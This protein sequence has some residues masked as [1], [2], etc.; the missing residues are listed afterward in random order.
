MF[1]KS[2]VNIMANFITIMSLTSGFLAAYL[3][4]NNKYIAGAIFFTLSGVLDV[5]DGYVARRTGKVT[6]FGS[7]LD[8]TVDKFVDGSVMGVLFIKHLGIL[9]GVV[10]TNIVV[11]HSIVKALFYLKFGKRAHHT[12]KFTGEIEGVG[13]FRRY[14]LFIIIPAAVIIES[15]GGRAMTESLVLIGI[16]ATISLAH[17]LYYIYRFEADETKS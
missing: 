5:L 12:E 10:F 11:M 9:V 13:I 3:F 16:T 14:F 8:W 2:K 7:L 6:K 1:K 15:F 4:Y 17:R